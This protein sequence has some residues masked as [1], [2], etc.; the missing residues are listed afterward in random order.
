MIG[1]GTLNNLASSSTVNCLEARNSA[2]SGLILICFQWIPGCSN[3]RFRGVACS[4]EYFSE[5]LF[6]MLKSVM[7]QVSIDLQSA[8]RI[9]TITV[10][11]IGRRLDAYSGLYD[12]R[13]PLKSGFAYQSII[14]AVP[15]MEYFVL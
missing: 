11:T 12:G 3:Q 10:E 6:E 15:Q 5:L 7:A 9:H 1:G 13:S 14:G 4:P 2:S 8:G